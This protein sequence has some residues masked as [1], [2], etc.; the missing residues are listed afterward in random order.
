MTLNK[1]EEKL[2]RESLTAL[3][4]LQLKIV[5]LRRIH[6]QHVKQ[7]GTGNLLDTGIYPIVQARVDLNR[8]PR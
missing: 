7:Y 6:N 8:P 1:Q 5:Q 4:R 2:K 3:E